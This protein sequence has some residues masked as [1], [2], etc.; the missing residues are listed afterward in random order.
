MAYTIEARSY[1]LGI[2]THNFWSL[3]DE[4]AGRTLA[5]LHGLAVSRVTGR[6]VPIGTSSEHGLRAYV[7][8]H[9][10]GY[11]ARLG[12][13]VTVTRMFD[14]SLARSIHE[15]ADGFD[16]WEAAVRAIPLMNEQDLDYPPWGFNFFGPTVNSNSAY[17]TFGEIMGVEIYDFPDVIGPGIEN[18]MLAAEEVARIRFQPQ[19]ADAVA[20]G[21]AAGR[22]A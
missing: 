2:W 17:R 7:F 9:E 22:R 11:A 19:K 4:T 1:R 5:E 3:R 12:F 6:I 20:R 10:A 21:G 14:V 16:R 15:G 13:K 18:R 8:A